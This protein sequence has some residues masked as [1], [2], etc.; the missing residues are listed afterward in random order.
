MISRVVLRGPIRGFRILSRVDPSF[1]FHGS[2]GSVRAALDSSSCQE[3]ILGSLVS[4]LE[5]HPIQAI[6]SLTEE[7][8]YYLTQEQNLSLAISILTVTFAWRL[9]SL[10]P[11]TIS[12]NN[13]LRMSKLHPQ[14]A[15]MMQHMNSALA[16]GD[17]SMINHFKQQRKELFRQ[18]N[19]SQAKGLYN[20]TLIPIFFSMF[21]LLRELPTICEQIAPGADRS[22]F[23][24]SD[25]TLKDPYFLIPVFSAFMT[26]AGAKIS[27][28]FA[29]VMEGPMKEIQN[30]LPYL[31]FIGIIP[32]ALFPAGLNLYFAAM[33]FSQIV[34]YSTIST[35]IYKKL[36][37][38]SDTDPEIK[39]MEVS[40]KDEILID[41]QQEV[42]EGENPKEISN[43]EKI[44]EKDN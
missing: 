27:Q 20:F 22:F 17:V 6:K 1:A 43:F 19:V 14:L 30:M 10:F 18:H 16:R 25:L 31:A 4:A 40:S 39:T 7:A 34:V 44:K 12:L 21:M 38:L 26:F 23:W 9:L 8:I 33:S 37:G 41:N 29:P 5:I 32:M 28:R 35:S 2:F 15:I 13:M 24:I 11:Q 3:P 36:I 42:V